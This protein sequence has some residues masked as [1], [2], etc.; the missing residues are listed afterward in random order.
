M[1]HRR[2]AGVSRYGDTSKKLLGY[3]MQ[4]IDLLFVLAVIL[5]ALRLPSAMSKIGMS[6]V[7]KILFT[8][9]S[10]AVLAIVWVIWR[11]V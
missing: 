6:R 3:H 1:V 7:D 2:Q 9:I 4:Q 10:F 11:S 8:L 5:L